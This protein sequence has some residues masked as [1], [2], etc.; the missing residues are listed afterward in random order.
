MDIF[1][2]IIA[3]CIAPY[4][5]KI[6]ILAIFWAFIYSVSIPVYLWIR[7]KQLFFIIFSAVTG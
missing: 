6:L 4:A 2:I 3:I 5:L 1:I 7:V